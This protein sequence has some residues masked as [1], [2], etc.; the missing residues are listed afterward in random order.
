MAK[1]LVGMGDNRTA[2]IVR[3]I[4]EE[5]R[6][7]VAV[8]VTWFTALCA[9]LDCEPGP[10]FRTLLVELLPGL[11]KGPFNDVERQV[12]GL[13]RELYDINLWPHTEMAAAKA[14]LEAVVAAERAGEPASVVVKSEESRTALA[15]LG[16]QPRLRQLA[17]RLAA[18]VDLEM[19]NATMA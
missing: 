14:A 5:E 4:A 2:A 3:R 11:L 10:A 17:A 8:G 18:M 16:D 19:A 7:H 15:P 13:P 1:R 6:A 9:A 12:V